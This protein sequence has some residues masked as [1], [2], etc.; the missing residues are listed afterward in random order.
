MRHGQPRFTPLPMDFVVLNPTLLF[1]FHNLNLSVFFRGF[2]GHLFIHSAWFA[3]KPAPTTTCI[4]LAV[5]SSLSM[6]S[7]LRMYFS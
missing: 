1:V 4:V 3:V 5:Y 6:P 2:R 7:A